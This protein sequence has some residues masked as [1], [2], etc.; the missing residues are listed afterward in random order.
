MASTGRGS[1]GSSSTSGGGGDSLLAKLLALLGIGGPVT[2]MAL[3]VAAREQAAAEA[4]AERVALQE[5][6]A[7]G[8]NAKGI[9]DIGER[10]NATTEFMNDLPDAVNNATDIPNSL[11]GR[12]PEGTTQGQNVTN[13]NTGTG[14]HFIP[15][16]DT[17]PDV[18]LASGILG[19]AAVGVAIGLWWRRVFG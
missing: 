10:N 17:S 14:T 12:A 7:A 11:S 9:A 4:A 3:E 13:T 2:D 5:S 15:P 8:I 16:V 19:L 1:S 18:S 6:Q